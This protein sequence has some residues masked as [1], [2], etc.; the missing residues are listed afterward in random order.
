MGGGSSGGP[1]FVSFDRHTG[2]GTVVG[3]NSHGYIPG[4]RYL[5]GPQFSTTITRPLF[6]RAQ[7][8]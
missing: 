3:D 6:E 7:H 4:K 5:V 1:R 8:S 2:F